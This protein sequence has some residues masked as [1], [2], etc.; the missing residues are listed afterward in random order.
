[1]NQIN[2]KKCIVKNIKTDNMR[3]FRHKNRPFKHDLTQEDFNVVR[4]RC[5]ETKKCLGGEKNVC[6]ES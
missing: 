1:M 6:K 5:F 2:L 3:P 4:Y